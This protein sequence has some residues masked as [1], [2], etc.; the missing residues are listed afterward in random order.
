MKKTVSLVLVMLILVG[1][2]AGCK[3]SSEKTQ[4]LNPS[5][6][7]TDEKMILIADMPPSP[8]IAEAVKLYK[9]L[10]FTH[11]ILTE[12]HTP[13][14]HD[15][16][17]HDGYKEAIEILAEEGFE[18]WIRN[19]QND[20]EYFQLTQQKSGSNYGYQYTLEPRDITD[21][22]SA[23]P[24][25]TGF[26][27]MDEP[28]QIT[29]TD[30]PATAD[31]EDLHPAIDQLGA[32]IEW[33]NT[34][35]PDAFWHV[36][37][38]GSGSWDHWPA[39]NTYADFIDA[40]VENVLKK[41]EG[42]GGKSICMD[43]YPLPDGG[44]V[45]KEVFLYDVLVLAHAT[46]NYNDTVPEEQQ[47][48]MG[49]CLQT[50]RDVSLRLRDITSSSDVTVQMYTGMACGAQLF[51]YFCYRSIDDIGLFGIVD[52]AGQPR[53]Y[54]YIAEANER[55]LPFQK[56]VC[57]FD[58]YGTTVNHGSQSGPENMFEAVGDM[59]ADET[60]VLTDVESRYDTVVGCFK[61][62]EQ[63]GYMV[64]NYTAPD[65]DQTNMVTLTFPGCTTALVYTEEGTNQVDL[66]EG[67]ILRVT[68]GCGQAAF[69][70]PV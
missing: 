43:H 32:L 66:V 68:L 19:M 6:Y 9:D 18:V 42:N 22:F 51:E 52:M 17:L 15:G 50:F 69:V 38:I 29:K 46:K 64:V 63:D 23:Y 55:A 57:A 34:Y 45:I 11:W 10:G 3:D 26:Y 41:L 58:W 49:I 1:M 28:F 5:D 8:F 70:I 7:E 20:P 31:R 27:M 25:V 60:G 35:Y 12:D 62:G 24:A 14:V 61:Q 54:D 37:H 30:D 13:M 44:G 47:A 39:G 21:D 65:L 53:I 33:K 40:Y 48:T 2:L 67:G 36:N 59:V 16:T 4:T 56:I